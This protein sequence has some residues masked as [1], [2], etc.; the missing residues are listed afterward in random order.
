MHYRRLEK[1]EVIQAG[2]E[3]DGCADPWRDM[4]VWKPV[5]PGNIGDAAPDPQY[6]AHRIFRRPIKEHTDEG[7]YETTEGIEP[8]D[9][10]TAI[11]AAQ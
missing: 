11:N 9:E 6:P 3:T 4:P 10:T 1:G 8:T 5:H 7:V 2:D